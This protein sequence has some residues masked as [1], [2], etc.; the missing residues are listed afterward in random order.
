MGFL[1]VFFVKQLDYQEHVSEYGVHWNF[2]I[3]LVLVGPLTIIIEPIFNYIPR[4]LVSIIISITYEWFIVN[5]E[6]FL[7]FLLIS[8]RTDFVSANREGIFSLIGYLAI[9]LAGQSTGYYLLPSISTKNN[10]FKLSTK[11][12][13]IEQKKQK[14]SVFDKLTTVSPLAGLAIWFLIYTGLFKLTQSEHDFNVSRRLANFPY[15]VWVCSYNTGF[16]FLYSLIDKLLSNPN[17]AYSDRISVSLDSINSNGMIIF[18]LANIST[19]SVN[20][21]LNTLDASVPV[22]MAVMIGYASWV[23]VVGGLLYYKKVTIKL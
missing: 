23:A 9:F 3:T 17:E 2:F 8:P 10:L 7:S 11:S 12:Q 21:L 15:V 13:I 18:L 1:R 20:I 22:S 5:K 16:L 4:S 19:G 6:G 14:F